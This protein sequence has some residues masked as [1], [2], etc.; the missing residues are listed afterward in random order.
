MGQV[1]GRWLLITLMMTV[2][3]LAAGSGQGGEPP[4]EGLKNLV[5]TVWYRERML[6]PPNAEITVRLE[7][8]ARMDVAAEVLATTRLIPQGGPPYAFELSYDP[9]RIDARGRYALRARIEA[10]GNLLFTNTSH[11]PAFEGAPGEPVE[12]LVSRVSGSAGTEPVSGSGVTGVTWRLVALDGEPASQGAGDRPVDMMLDDSG[13]VSGFS[14]C[15]RFMGTYARTHNRL[16]FSQLASTM[17]A[18][19][20][21][22]DLEQ[23]FLDALAGVSAYHLDGGG[24]ALLDDQGK[25]ILSFESDRSD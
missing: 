12:I 1:S 3:G 20:E 5:G 11:V 23:R 17:M 6:L 7:N 16:S 19:P 9:T 10:D 2:M 8:I 18:C 22:M 14:G 21:G 4:E 24:L 25:V 15:N 13:R